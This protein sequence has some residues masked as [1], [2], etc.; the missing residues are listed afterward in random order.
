MRAFP[1]RDAERAKSKAEKRWYTAGIPYRYWRD[2][3]KDE[4]IQ[5]NNLTI[6]NDQIITRAQQQSLFDSMLRAPNWY[7][8][9]VIVI[10]SEPTD[11]EALALTIRLA[12][13]MLV[14]GKDI[15]MQDMGYRN[16]K[17]THDDSVAYFGYNVVGEMTW[18][19][20]QRIRDWLSKFNDRLRIL[21]VA[22]NP[23]ETAVN[24][25]RWEP[26]GVIYIGGDHQ[27]K[28]QLV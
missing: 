28:M 1:S 20:K 7:R 16:I 24:Q 3:L 22:G 10:G 21:A 4:R 25:L 2:P 9:S 18:E 17:E 26:E 27:V 13:A 15:T 8:P 11:T 5:F 19:R 12:K 23:Y 14:K 6:N